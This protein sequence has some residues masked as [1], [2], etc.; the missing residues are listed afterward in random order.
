M[1]EKKFGYGSATVMSQSKEERLEQLKNTLQE[2]QTIEDASVTHTTAVLETTTSA[3]VR[4]VMEIMRQDSVMHKKVQQAL[5]DSLAPDSLEKGALGLQPEELDDV[6]AIL[7][8]HD[9]QEQRAIQ[10]AEHAREAC[11]L[12]IQRHLLDYLLEDERKHERLVA[13]LEDF[14]RSLYPDA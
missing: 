4:L 2:W 12:A 1:K 10:M 13:Y 3:L 11:P 9:E 8:K 5:L 7:E 6:W 14:E